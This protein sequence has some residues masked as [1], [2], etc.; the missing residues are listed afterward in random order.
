MKSILVI[1]SFGFLGSAFSDEVDYGRHVT[2][3]NPGEGWEWLPVKLD[4]AERRLLA[5]RS[6]PPKT[7][8]DY[9]LLLPEKYFRNIENSL[10]RRVTFIDQ[11]SLSDQYLRAGYTIPSTDA[12]AFWVT[13]RLFEKGGEPLIAI[14]HRGGN[15]LLHKIKDERTWEPGELIWISLGRPDF[16]R[17]R[18][19]KWIPVGA[20]ILPPITKDF[21]LDRYRN[22]Y[23]GHL[24]HPTQKKWIS[25]GYALP[26]TGETVQVTGRENFMNPLEKYIW[27]E[28]TFDGDR[29]VKTTDREPGGADQSATAPK[30]KSESGGESKPGADEPP[31]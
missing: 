21:V 14:R 29:F 12:G 3:R 26:Q 17:Y 13:I 31:P 15:Q 11:E 2:L 20:K 16:L 23:K 9:Y 18:E 24:K 10:E 22:H 5:A 4:E 19:G 25:L 27:A 1:L 7:A 30:P 28:F 8:M 6:S